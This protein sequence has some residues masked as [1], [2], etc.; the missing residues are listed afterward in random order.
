MH[1]RGKRGAATSAGSGG[2]SGSGRAHAGP[3]RPRDDSDGRV[4]ASSVDVTDGRLPVVASRGGDSRRGQPARVV[5]G[6]AGRGAPQVAGDDEEDKEQ[7]EEGG[8]AAGEDEADDGDDNGEGAEGD[9]EEGEDGDDDDGDDEEE[10]DDL[11]VDGDALLEADSA[12]QVGV[13]VRVGVRG[14]GARMWA[15]SVGAVNCFER[16]PGMLLLVVAPP[17]AVVLHARA[18]VYRCSCVHALAFF[19][20]LAPVQRRWAGERVGVVAGAG[21]GAGVC[22]CELAVCWEPC[23]VTRAPF[24]PRARAHPPPDANCTAPLLTHC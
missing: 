8:S 9:G 11:F 16:F 23:A 7:E 22:W 14:A 21:A 6:R 13:W 10:D 15:A 5:H 18:H 19:L 24:S 20:V 3:H 4:A 17:R 12:W 1:P 2:D